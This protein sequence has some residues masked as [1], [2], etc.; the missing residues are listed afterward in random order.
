[1]SSSN[2]VK[3]KKI[4]FTLLLLD[5]STKK[6]AATPSTTIK[7]MFLNLCEKLDLVRNEFFTLC[8]RYEE[9]DHTYDRFLDMDKTLRE[10]ILDASSVIV[11]KIKYLKQFVELNDPVAENLIFLTVQKNVILEVYPSPEKTAL[12]LAALSI[13]SRFGDFDP[14]KHKVG[15]LNKVGLSAFLPLTVSR[16]DYAYWQERLFS[17][18]AKLGGLSKREAKLKYINEAKNIPYFGMQFFEVKDSVSQ[19]TTG[20]AEDGLYL[21]NSSELI[22]I[23]AITFDYLLSWEKSD[24]GIIIRHCLRSGQEETVPLQAPEVRSNDMLELLDIYYALSDKKNEETEP[25]NAKPKNLPSPD[26]FAP[27]RERVFLGRFSSRLEYLKGYYME[28]CY[29]KTVPLRK[30]CFQVDTA[31]DTDAKMQSIDASSADLNDIQLKFI[32]DA[33]TCALQYPPQPDY[34]WTENLDIV[35]FDVS[36]NNLGLDTLT[37]LIEILKLLPNLKTFNISGNTLENK[38]ALVIAPGFKNCNN[39]E[40]VNVSHCNIGN[41]GIT[42][43]IEACKASPSFKKL[44]ANDNRITDISMIKCFNKFLQSNSSVT[45][46]NLA[47]NKTEVKGLDAVLDGI[48]QNKAL[49]EFD[50]SGNSIGGNKGAAKIFEALEKNQSIKVLKLANCNFTSE[51]YVKLGQ[52]LRTRKLTG[53]DFSNNSFNKVP[54]EHQKGVSQYLMDDGVELEVLKIVGCG[55]GPEVGDF[56]A[57]AATKCDSLKELHVGGNLLANDHGKLP[58]NWYQMIKSNSNITTLD[59]SDNGIKASGFFELIDTIGSNDTL[60]SLKLDS[61]DIGEALDPFIEFIGEGCNLE[62]ISL[63]KMHITDEHAKKIA[64]QLKENTKLKHLNLSFNDVSKI[65]VEHFIKA[66][67]HNSTLTSLD[68]SNNLIVKDNKKQQLAKQ[69]LTTSV[70]NIMF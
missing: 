9:E 3:E 27:P 24:N 47:R 23:R 55:I 2:E 38:G 33:I 1:M 17:M 32:T 56:L 67:Q 41:K 44:I 59:I 68:F 36:H 49:I 53:I 25:N 50:F 40:V 29:E 11:F 4:V 66:L 8:E 62:S 61:N 21:F 52:L 7:E 35:N 31:I 43:V 19:L 39:I 63:S 16:H 18:H 57:E 69:F 48:S 37:A 20:I 64:E 14:K 42:A 58:S 12:R 30:F 51:T 26:I 10:E 70:N 65:G 5:D 13:Q 60:Q 45:H 34:P 28:S 22:M 46:L 6:L 54:S 15:Y